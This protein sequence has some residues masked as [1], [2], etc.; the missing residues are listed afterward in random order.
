MHIKYRVSLFAIAANIGLR[1]CCCSTD[2]AAYQLELC[3]LN[4]GDRR[5]VQLP[6]IGS[7]EGISAKKSKVMKHYTLLLKLLLSVQQQLLASSHW[8]DCWSHVTYAAVF[9][10]RIAKLVLLQHGAT[11]LTG[12][13]SS[14]LSI[15]IARC[16]TLYVSTSARCAMRDKTLSKA[17]TSDEMMLL[18]N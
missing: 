9:M 7:L 8:Y 5:P 2:V 3:D 14:A 12:A 1:L 17:R 15:C 6:S 4:G 11:M 18:H 13:V 10:S 16:N